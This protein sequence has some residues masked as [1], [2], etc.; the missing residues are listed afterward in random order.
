MT[1]RSCS[2][3]CST[4]PWMF[5]RFIAATV[6]STASLMALSAQA[7]CCW[8]WSCSANCAMR[9]CSSSGSP[10]SPPKPSLPS[11]PPSL[12]GRGRPFG[13]PGLPAR[14]DDIAEAPEAEDEHDRREAEGERE[15]RD[16]DLLAHGVGRDERRPLGPEDLDEQRLLHAGAAGGEGHGGGHR[17]DAE[18]QQHVAHRAADVERVEDPP[19]R[20]KA[21]HPPRQLDQE[22]L[23]H[24]APAVEEDR[25][26]L[27]DPGPEA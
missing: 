13:A 24:V 14:G 2:A 12:V 18:H 21:E 10:N 19:E 4:V 6:R 11:M 3:C 1:E 8:P 20:G 26:P 15:G 5:T 16:G 22:H 7:S 25:Q 23:A 27:L 17:V 9:R